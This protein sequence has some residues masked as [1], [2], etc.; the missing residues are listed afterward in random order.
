MKKIIYKTAKKMTEFEAY[1]KAFSVATGQKN[2]VSTAFLA[3]AI[4][5]TYLYNEG[6][7]TP[8]AGFVLNLPQTVSESRY[9]MMLPE[10]KRNACLEHLR[11]KGIHINQVCESV[12]IF[13]TKQMSSFER[14]SFFIYAIE[15]AR[16]TQKE[17][18]LSGSYIQSFRSSLKS[19]YQ[20]ILFEGIAS[21]DEKLGLYYDYSR[22][23]RINLVSA[24]PKYLSTQILKKSQK[25]LSLI[26]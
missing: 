19:V 23:V 18:T 6:D 2:T 22:N 20:N 16:K 25:I 5:V 9:L 8:I 11:L 7:I 26:F 1:S 13:C 21:N 24:V 15:Q 12:T 3:K 17:V 10:T 14:V 4:Q